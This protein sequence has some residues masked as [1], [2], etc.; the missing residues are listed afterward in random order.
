V[1]PAGGVVV[2]DARLT[3]FDEFLKWLK[4]V[5]PSMSGSGGTR[6]TSYKRLKRVSDGECKRLM[7]FLPPRHGKSELVTVRYTAFRL[8]QDP[9]LNVIIGATTSKLANRFSRKIRRVLSEASQMRNAECGSRNEEGAST[10]EAQSRG[11]AADSESRVAE[12]NFRSCGFGENT[13]APR[14]H[15]KKI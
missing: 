8:Q 5:S 13:K 10:A 14:K 9:K 3:D 7:I 1:K 6:S 15:T 2:D 11:E 4:Q 12:R